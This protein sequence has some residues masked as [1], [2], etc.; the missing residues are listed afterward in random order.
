MILT[1]TSSVTRS[2]TLV[3]YRVWTDLS[4]LSGKRTSIRAYPLDPREPGRNKYGN[5]QIQIFHLLSENDSALSTDDTLK[6][7]R[8]VLGKCSENSGKP[9]AR[10]S[11]VA[12]WV[13]RW[14]TDLADR[15]RS[16]LEIFS[17]VNRAALHKAFHYQPPMI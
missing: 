16:S 6:T 9:N 15:I 12:Q 3:F 14:P 5:I 13:K 7:R 8:G 1:F 4:V 11:P 2:G 10:G 17:T